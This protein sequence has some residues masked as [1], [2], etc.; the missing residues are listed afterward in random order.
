MPI[1]YKRIFLFQLNSSSWSNPKFI[2]TYLNNNFTFYNLLHQK[3]V[4][5]SQTR[6]YGKCAKDILYVMLGGVAPG[7]RKVRIIRFPQKDIIQMVIWQIDVGE[8]GG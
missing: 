1:K 4:L 8:G 5:W 2:N 3:I 7:R 6:G